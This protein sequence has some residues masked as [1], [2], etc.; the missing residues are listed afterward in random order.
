MRRIFSIITLFS[1]AAAAA[2]GYKPSYGKEQPRSAIV[3]YPSADEAAVAGV[4]N[5]TYRTQL[6]DWTQS[7]TRFSTSFTVPFAWVNRQVL[8]HI[9]SASA[10]YEVRLNG[11]PIAFNADAGAPA[12]FN[13]TKQAKEGRNQIEIELSAAPAT[14]ALE[15]W[16]T[17]AKPT[18]GSVWVFTQP[19]LRVRDIT[20]NTWIEKDDTGYATAEVAIAVKCDALNP[21]TSRIYYDLQSRTG[22]S[23]A[24]GHKDITIDMRHEDTVRFLA[25]IPVSHLWSADL[26]TQHT[27]RL[28]TQHEGRFVE[29]QEYRIGLRALEMRDGRMQINGEPVTLRV[30]DVPGTAGEVEVEALR[31]K[32]FNTL[33]LLPGEVSQALLDYCDAQGLYVIVRAPIDSSRSGMSRRKG[34]N[35]TND[36]TRLTAYTERTAESYHA[37]KRHPSVVAF[38]LATK[39]ANGINLYESYLKM[40]ELGDSRPFVY[41]DAAGEWNSDKL[42]V[43]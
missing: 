36:P 8:L 43:E 38:E 37:A 15:S 11:V 3:V 32:G 31:A 28:R 2:Q 29:Y 34:G 14:A 41:L 7:G 24:I 12:E 21:R 20:T 6:G 1:V 23:V 10:D 4:G 19:T 39:S 9:D 18:L 25:R 30:A 22:E 5:N 26:P 13:L 40:K 33:R 42:V 35:P 27:L 16:R 17:A